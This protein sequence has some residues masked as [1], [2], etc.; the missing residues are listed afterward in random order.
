MKK[1][2]PFCRR[3]AFSG[4]GGIDASQEVPAIPTRLVRLSEE[5]PGRLVVPERSE[6]HSAGGLGEGAVAE[7]QCSG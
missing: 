4:S 2:I 3:R 5:L 1:L 6:A 7:A